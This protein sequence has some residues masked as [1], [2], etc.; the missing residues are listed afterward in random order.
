MGCRISLTSWKDKT[1]LVSSEAEHSVWDGGVGI[2]KFSRET[3]H[4]LANYIKLF[5]SIG[6]GNFS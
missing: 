2:S 6:R 4:P 5:L 1:S 3:K